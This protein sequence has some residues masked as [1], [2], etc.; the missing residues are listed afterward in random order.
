MTT[1]PS[2]QQLPISAGGYEAVV[3]ECGATLRTLAYAGREIVAGFPEGARSDSGRG[4]LLLPWPNRIA[5]GRYSFAGEEHQLPLSEVRRG[6][7]SHGL[8]RWA[9][10]SVREHT[11]AAADLGYRLMAQ[12]GY[13]WTLD[14]SARYALSERGLQVTVTAANLSAAPAPFAAGAH[15][16]VRLGQG[17]VDGW[18]LALPA[19]TALT[20]DEQMIPVG[21]QDVTGTDLDFRGGRLIGDA[22]LD[23]AFTDLER[24]GDGLAEVVV[25]D[26]DLGV[27]VWMDR[28]HSWVQVYAGVE[29]APRTVLAVEP[30][31]APPDAFNSG[32]G[33]LVLSP[34]GEPGDRC[35]A[36]WGIRAQA[37]GM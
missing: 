15:P 19:G 8:V 21:R 9:A 14:L 22:V 28:A 32:E 33:L 4:Q 29:D 13:P 25:G 3:T 2:G 24:S 35:T 34:A 11:A 17:P 5:G 6:N 37:G 31:T 16:Y 12:P 18:H 10:W 30:M 7:A 26:G 1:P 27:T 36:T 20:V 23:T